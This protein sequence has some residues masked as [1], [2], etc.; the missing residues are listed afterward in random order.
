MRQKMKHLRFL[1]VLTLLLVVTIMV[2]VS[3]TSAS[4]DYYLSGIVV[5]TDKATYICGDQVEALT[6]LYSGNVTVAN[7]PVSVQI[8]SPS[9]DQLIFQSNV[10]NSYG[11]ASFSLLL[12]DACEVGVY[13]VTATSQGKYNSV[14]SDTKFSIGNP[15]EYFALSFNKIW[16]SRGESLVLSGRVITEC[17]LTL[18]NSQP[19]QFQIYAP[20]NSSLTSGSTQ[21]VGSSF[22][23]LTT[24][25]QSVPS[26]LYTAIVYVLDPCQNRT[27][28]G[29][30]FFSVLS[31]VVTHPWGISIASDKTVYEVGDQ[32][33]LIG[34]VTGGPYFF[35]QL[36][37]VCTGNGT[38]PPID[39]SIQIIAEN[40]TIVYSR[41]VNVGLE[42]YSPSYVFQAVFSG[43]LNNAYLAAGTYLVA[44]QASTTG[45]PTV[46]TATSF[47][48][49]ATPTV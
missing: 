44:A 1:S 17:N 30:A 10:T 19:I 36:G 48:V 7:L 40:G 8:A 14:S 22:A 31:N 47:T 29:N 41:T 20:D 2:N 12:P 45:Y 6:A 42:Y 26:G 3:M 43:Y 39:V 23:V 16:Y 15:G 37:W 46:Q 21:L 24:L 28:Y 27:I 13:T 5:G 38:Y 33:G 4:M 34:S 9:G 25:P 32:I 35:C 49:A 11:I 18:V